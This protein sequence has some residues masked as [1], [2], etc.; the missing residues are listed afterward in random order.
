MEDVK[1]ELRAIALSMQS[2]RYEQAAIKQD[3]NRRFDES[4]E[5]QRRMH[6]E[7]SGRLDAINGRVRSAHEKISALEAV[8]RFVQSEI[9]KLWARLTAKADGDGKSFTY[10]DIKIL[11]ALGGVIAAVI[12]WIVSHQT[13]KP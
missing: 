12:L 13:V 5:D 4:R 9:D 2:I 10:G 11:L 7:N 6:T 3:M 1:E 8:I